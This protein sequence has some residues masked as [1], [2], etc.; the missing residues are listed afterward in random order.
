MDKWH[1]KIIERYYADISNWGE[2]VLNTLTR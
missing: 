2:A 1:G